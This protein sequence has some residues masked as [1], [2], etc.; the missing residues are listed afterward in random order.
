MVDKLKLPT[1]EHPQPYKFHWLNKGNVVKVSKQCLMT[2]S[3]GNR[4]CDEV[5]CDVAPMDAYHLL[6]ARPWQY[7]R[8]A[9]HNERAN[10]Y[11][12]TKDGVKFILVPLPPSE[13][14]QSSR[15]S[16][17]SK[18]LVSLI[19]KEEFKVNDE[20]INLPGVIPL[21]S[22]FSNVIS[23]EI[24]PGLP[25]IRDIQHAIDFIPGAV[26]PNKPAYRMSL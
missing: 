9:M 17:A 13:I 6:L 5:L 22:E 12:F 11:S 7:D 18:P 15:E 16:S 4:Y 8:H 1:Q 21:L 10:T 3:I 2:F 26:I 25:P 20:S 14:S 23:D 24:P 19:T